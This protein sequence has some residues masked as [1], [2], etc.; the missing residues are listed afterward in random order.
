MKD[1]VPRCAVLFLLVL[2]PG[3][4]AGEMG[5]YFYRP[6]PYGSEAFYNPWNNVFAY[7]FDTVQLTDNFDTQDMSERWDTVLDHLTH[8]GDAIDEDGGTRAFVN[9]QIFP[10]GGEDHSDRYC[11]TPNYFLHLFGGGLVYRKDAEYFQQKGIPA[12]R[13]CSAILAM[14]G[15]IVQEVIEK[16]S[17]TSDD[18]VADV[19]IFRPLGI[20]LFSSDMVAGFVETHLCPAVWPHLLLYDVND[21]TLLNAGMNYVIRPNLLGCESVRLFSFIGMNNM[22]GLSHRISPETSLSWG[23]GLATCRV[24]L[25]RDIPAEFRY[26]GGVFYDRNN[27]LLWSVIINGTENLKVRLNV[28]PTAKPIWNKLGFFAGLTD[29]RKTALG[30][31]FNFPFGMGVSF[32]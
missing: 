10:L 9:R 4:C 7:T 17:T 19:L 21:E 5:C 29:D 20:L 31:T 12:P 3:I 8:P 28:Y 13:A 30:I 2:A 24:D 32:H 23:L 14:A 25:S 16:K 27:S 22:I 11:M 15:E 18:E 26:S 1:H 6:Q